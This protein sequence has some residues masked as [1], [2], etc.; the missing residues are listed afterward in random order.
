[1]FRLNSP[2]GVRGRIMNSAGRLGNDIGAS[3]VERRGRARCAPC[4]QRADGASDQSEAAKAGQPNLFSHMAKIHTNRRVHGTRPG[5][6][7][8]EAQRHRRRRCGPAGTRPSSERSLLQRR[9][10]L[11]TTV[12]YPSQNIQ[13]HSASNKRRVSQHQF[14]RKK[15]TTFLD[16]RKIKHTEQDADRW[17][18][19]G[20]SLNAFGV[21]SQ[22]QAFTLHMGWPFSSGIGPRV[23]PSHSGQPIEQPFE[24]WGG[25][26][27]IEGVRVSWHETK[28]SRRALRSAWVRQPSAPRSRLDR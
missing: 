1:M 22:L 18:A 3:P 21:Y 25:A 9:G 23:T 19:L 12:A 6:C 27:G 15:M 11:G 4:K 10:R 14:W 8:S 13:R 24:N 16:H 5:C 2:S 26:R 17:A 7:M 28:R 20:R